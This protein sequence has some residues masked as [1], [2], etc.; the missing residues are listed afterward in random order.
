M[1]YKKAQNVAFQK[2]DHLFTN[3]FRRYSC[4]ISGMA[5]ETSLSHVMILKKQI[6]RTHKPTRDRDR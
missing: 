4:P 3:I 6:Q 2:H 5:G 1:S